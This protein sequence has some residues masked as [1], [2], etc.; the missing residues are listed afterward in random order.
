MSLTVLSEMARQLL[1][2][3]I[4]MKFDTKFKVPQQI[5][6]GSGKGGRSLAGSQEE[7]MGSDWPPL[8]NHQLEDVVVQCQN[9]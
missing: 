6:F 5:S 3:W 8:Q 1:D 9:I 4:T 2:V 7:K